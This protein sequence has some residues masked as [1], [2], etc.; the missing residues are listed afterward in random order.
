M[1][2]CVY[3]TA[4]DFDLLVQKAFRLI[5]ESATEHAPLGRPPVSH[6]PMTSTSGEDWQGELPAQST[7]AAKNP[8]ADLAADEPSTSQP[9]HVPKGATTLMLRNIP[10]SLN[11]T[12]VREELASLG[13][14]GTYNLLNLPARPNAS[15]K[16]YGFINF[17]TS[18]DAQRFANVF[19]DYQFKQ[20]TGSEKKSNVSLARLQGY[21]ANSAR[22]RFQ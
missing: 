10:C 3:E 9:L 6:A 20:Y 1:P 13:F 22:L 19:V 14:E 17:V 15:T 4:L 7:P 11:L 18:E 8:G 16:G 21:D 2:S 12:K 5:G